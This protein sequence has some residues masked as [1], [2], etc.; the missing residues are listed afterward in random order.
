VDPAENAI[1]VPALFIYLCVSMKNFPGPFLLALAVLAACSRSSPDGAESVA[2]VATTT[3][4][5][6]AS[7][8]RSSASGTVASS[9][10]S[11]CPRTGMWATCSVE[12]R[13]GQS[14]FVVRRVKEEAPRRPGFS[15]PPVAYNLGKT[16][17]EVFIYPSEAALAA[18]MARIDTVIAAPRGARNPWLMIPTF[19]RS[20]N[21][22][23]VFLTENPTQAERLTLAL[24][25]GAPQ[26]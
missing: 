6:S 15:V 13:L 3:L 10:T 12:T 18:D 21:L 8:F 1:A 2:S 26:R 5:E 9:T 25:A 4:P 19:V 17:L 11:R 16:R 23:A 14:G 24:T 22:A 7:T 20:A